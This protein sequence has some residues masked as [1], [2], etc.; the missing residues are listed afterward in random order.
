MFLFV[1]ASLLLTLLLIL[2]LV[3]VAVVAVAVVSADLE[4]GNDFFQD[5]Q[6]D[7][8]AQRYTVPHT[9]AS[10][11]DVLAEADTCAELRDGGLPAGK[12]AQAELLAAIRAS[13]VDGIPDDLLTLD[14][15]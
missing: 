10:D 15:Y 6:Q 5:F 1:L 9:K 2:L 11:V 13:W 4:T 14:M 8:K 12:A 7:E 3:V